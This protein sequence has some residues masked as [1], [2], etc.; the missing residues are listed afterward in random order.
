MSESAASTERAAALALELAGETR[1]ALGCMG[2]AGTYGRVDRA[3]AERTL[4]VALDSGVRLFD[5][6]PLY[7]DGLAEELLGATLAGQPIAIATKFGLTA[8]A[9]GRLVRDS[10][11]STVRASVEASLRR[12]R[13]DRVDV[14]LQHRPDPN[15]SDD[16]V[17]EAL[18]RLVE[19]GK[20]THVGLSHTGELRTR[21][22]RA[23]AP[24]EFVQNEMS[25]AVVLGD[26]E[27][28]AD[29]ASLGV[30]FMAHSPLARGILAGRAPRRF[31]AD[32][33]RSRMLDHDAADQAQIIRRARA[34]GVGVGQ[35]FPVTE[36]LNWVLA[37]GRSVIAVVGARSPE[38]VREFVLRSG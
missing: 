6:A 11:P 9:D 31:E 36:A 18:L 10:R 34:R 5:A 2:L 22:F 29:F 19:E 24:I 12:L 8:A 35:G 33:Y 32:D 15:V 21:Q 1:L 4:M 26:G 37:Q 20:A 14:L 23:R 16:D 27:G 13:R 3:V 17:A 30:A 28:V 7:G 25:A 38:Q